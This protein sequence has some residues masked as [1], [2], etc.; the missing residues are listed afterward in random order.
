MY[1]IV[2][3]KYFVAKPAHWFFLVF[4]FSDQVVI[5]LTLHFAKDGLLRAAES[6]PHVKQH[7][8]CNGSQRVTTHASSLPPELSSW[9]FF[10]RSCFVLFFLL[11]ATKKIVTN[12]VRFV[13]LTS[14]N[15]AN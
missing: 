7:K 4:F 1:L 9:F 15:Y 11:R 10:L 3:H 13:K 2:T 6:D 14:R 5:S 12:D 8:S